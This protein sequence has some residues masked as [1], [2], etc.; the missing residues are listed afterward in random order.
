MAEELF[1][2]LDDVADDL[3]EYK[4]QCLNEKDQFPPPWTET[5]IAKFKSHRAALKRRVDDKEKLMDKLE[6]KVKTMKNDDETKPALLQRIHQWKSEHRKFYNEVLDLIDELQELILVK[7]QP[8]SINSRGDSN[9]SLITNATQTTVTVTVPDLKLPKF[10]GD[11]LKWNSFWQRFE[12]A[13]HNRPFPKIE[14]L[15][16]LLGYLEGR[17]L[18]AVEGFAVL[19]ESYD[20]VIETLVHRFGRKPLI[21][22]DLQAKLRRIEPAKPNPQSLRSTVDLICN[23]C[24]QLQ[25]LGVNIDNDS[26]KMD[27]IGKLPLREKKDLNWFY[28]S[29]SANVTIEMLIKKMQD[30]VFKSELDEECTKD[31]PLRA[32]TVP[33]KQFPS[34]PQQNLF[35]EN[36][37]S[38]MIP[39]NNSKFVTNLPHTQVGHGNNFS[40]NLCDTDDHWA[41]NCQKFIS[42]E[43]KLKRLRERN[44]CTKC[45]RSNHETKDCRAR[46]ACRNCGEDHYYMLCKKPSNNSTAFV[47]V[48]KKQGALITKAVKIVNL[49]TKEA[50]ETVALFDSGSQ[51]SYISNKVIE[52]LKLETI[53]EEKVNINGFGAKLS[54]YNSSLVKYGMQ[55]NHGYKEIFANSTKYITSTVPVTE[56]DES[57][58]ILK[59]A[60]KT[61]GI[62]IGMDYFFD[63][64][65]S[66]KK[67]NDNLFIINSNVGKIICKKTP[68]QY[69]V[70]VTSLANTSSPY[71]DKNENYLQNTNNAEMN[72]IQNSSNKKRYRKYEIQNCIKTLDEKE[73]KLFSKNGKGSIKSETAVT[74]VND[75]NEESEKVHELQLCRKVKGENKCQPSIKPIQAQKLYDDGLLSNTKLTTD[76]DV[77]FDYPI[78]KPWKPWTSNKII[79]Q[80]KLDM[81]QKEKDQSINKLQRQQK[82]IKSLYSVTNVEDVTS[83]TSNG[84]GGERLVK[85]YKKSNRL[86]NS[87]KIWYNNGLKEIIVQSARDEH[88]N[89]FTKSQMECKKPWKDKNSQKLFLFNVKN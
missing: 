25:N 16:S 3:Q 26:M 6:N 32:E 80:L 89:G 42:A 24:R 28:H 4:D 73:G 2:D 38:N 64:I 43:D 19:E 59:T 44:Y 45:A 40:C 27:I 37:N 85:N 39:L 79:D 47:S 56:A 29:D 10:D 31:I 23:I 11:Y 55:T 76:S 7:V 48:G 67:C 9:E 84:C 14:K 22:K 1:E 20:T 50:T 5:Q 12:H 30:Y 66:F 61:P 51:Q 81:V 86:F 82:C 15:I 71:F 83:K 41:G 74:V 36:Q 65:N 21:I 33:K 58:N 78:C 46:T 88:K 34:Y 62:L 75:S 52:Q 17:A 13:V 35:F 68:K 49:V 54:S 87:K 70:T 57:T 77:I 63:I 72:G 60:Y 53:E 18:E 8:E 69:K